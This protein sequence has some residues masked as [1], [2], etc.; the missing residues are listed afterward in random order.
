MKNKNAFIE[1][2]EE[3]AIALKELKR[4]FVFIGGA[5][6]SLYMEDPAAPSI[7]PTEDVD[8]IVEISTS[9]EYAKLEEELRK[10]K[11]I[12]DMTTNAPICRWKYLGITVDIMPVD[13]AILGFSNKWY[14]EGFKNAKT[15]KL[16]KGTE[17]LIFTLPY[18]LASKFEAFHGRGED[19]PR[20]SQDIED[21]ILVIGGFCESPQW[22]PVVDQT[23]TLLN[24][25]VTFPS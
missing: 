15:A 7:R 16:P 19:D 8:C 9:G 3:V 17:I 13:D 1:M 11:F 2:T 20:L 14:K 10:I 5:M 21:I 18:F 4:S 12:N 6:V 22:R 25:K 24:F 23:T